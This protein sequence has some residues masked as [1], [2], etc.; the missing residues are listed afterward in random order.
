[1]DKYWY[2]GINKEEAIEVLRKCMNEAKHR[3]S[4]SLDA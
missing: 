2:E 4:A 1:M 3:M